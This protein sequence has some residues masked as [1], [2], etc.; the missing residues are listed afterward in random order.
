VSAPVAPAGAGFDRLV[1]AEW[2][3]LR[4]LRSTWIVLALVLALMVTISILGAAGSRRDVAAI[5]N[6]PTV[7]DTLHFVY[8]PLAGDG[9]V[10]A[11]VAAQTDSQEFARAGIMV[12]AGTT[13]GTPNASIAVTPVHGVRWQANFA[14]DVPGGFGGAPRWLKLVRAGSTVTGY[15]SSDGNSWTQVGSATVPLPGTVQIGLFVTSPPKVTTT[16]HGHNQ[17]VE[18]EP[19]TG[20]ATFDRVAVQP[21]TGQPATRWADT[22]ISRLLTGPGPHE[23]SLQAPGSSTLAGGVFT[24]TG[25][26]DLGPAPVPQVDDDVIKQALN[27]VQVALIAVIAL[28][29][30]C[31]TAEYRSGLVR[32]TFTAS[33]R[34]GRVLA[35]KSVALALAIFP[36]GLLGGVLS[37]L[38]ARPIQRHNGFGP[39]TFPDR[40]L[41]D[42][43]VLRVV[44]GTALVLVAVALVALAAG[45]LLRRTAGAVVLV[46]AVVVVPEIVG[47]SLSFEA[48]QWVD[49][50]TPVAG[51]AIQQT[52]HNFDTAISPWGGFAVLCGYVLVGLGLAAWLL[53]RRDA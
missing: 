19:T 41:L 36:V 44:V 37:Y 31:M 13:A 25:S 2:T 6:G 50:V 4:S 20:Q 42:G 43:T 16:R 17:A 35:A 34:R 10:V 51:L 39:P 53:S 48:G 5:G 14:A 3:K 32:T 23:P 40:S 11:R 1:R 52:V 27:G 29:V 12:R 15:A 28:G 30:L 8:Q 26:G 38:I 21:A 33:P 22:D 46:L 45:T 7:R 9:T 18:A 49:R 47:P 24:V